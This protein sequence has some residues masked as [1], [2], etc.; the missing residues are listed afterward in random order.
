MTQ[1][2]KIQNSTTFKTLDIFVAENSKKDSKMLD[3][4]EEIHQIMQNDLLSNE[5]KS[6]YAKNQRKLILEYL[7]AIRS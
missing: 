2:I 6:E 1:K 5:M 4:I 3:E 7:K